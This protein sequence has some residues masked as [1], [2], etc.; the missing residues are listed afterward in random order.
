MAELSVD[1]VS[2]REKMQRLSQL[3]VRL[4]AEVAKIADLTANLDIFW[5][6]DANSV[7]VAAIAED[8]ID[9][10]V[11]MMRIRKTVK[12]IGNAMDIYMENEKEV[13]R[14]IEELKFAGGRR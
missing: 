12:L 8:L 5:D 3:V 7:F 13:K 10:E 9:T 1:Y 4:D 14:M 2:L 6:G 11:I